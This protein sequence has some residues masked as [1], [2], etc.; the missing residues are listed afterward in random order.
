MRLL[1]IRQ[2]SQGELNKCSHVMFGRDG[3]LDDQLQSQNEGRFREQK[4]TA[5][6]SG[7]RRRDPRLS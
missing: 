3:G 4:R 2:A 6:D 5:D 1:T 7:P